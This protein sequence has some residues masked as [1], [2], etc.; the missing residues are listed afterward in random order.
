MI[1][2]PPRST[3]FPYPPLFRSV[4]DAGLPE[5]IL[6][7]VSDTHPQLV[8]AAGRTA[9]A[10]FVDPATYL[11]A[12]PVPT[13]PLEATVPA[14]ADDDIGDYIGLRHAVRDLLETVD[15]PADVLEDFLMAVDER[16][17]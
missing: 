7:S 12:L 16:S 3:L 8:T 2:R 6:A 9:N 1:R 13:E 10:D 11:R 15:G 5:P 14:L 4:F 17:E